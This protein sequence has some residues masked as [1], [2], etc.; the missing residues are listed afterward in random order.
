MNK[1]V[2]VSWDVHNRRARTHTLTHAEAT[3][4]LDIVQRTYVA[5]RVGD[6]ANPVHPCFGNRCGPEGYYIISQGNRDGAFCGFDPDFSSRTTQMQARTHANMW[7]T[8]DY[9]YL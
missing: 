4:G 8:L 9:M 5:L 1:G 7:L 3:W 6:L 2:L